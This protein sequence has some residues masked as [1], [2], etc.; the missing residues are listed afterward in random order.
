[1]TN[2]IGSSQISKWTAFVLSISENGIYTLWD[3]E[4]GSYHKLDD[5]LCPLMKVSRLI[6][7]FGVSI[8]V[9]VINLYKV[10]CTSVIT[11]NVFID[12]GEFAK[13]SSTS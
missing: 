7:Y 13:I 1:M 8:T 11:S 5:S 6:N 9:S 2:V 12:M 3:P 4:V 10:T